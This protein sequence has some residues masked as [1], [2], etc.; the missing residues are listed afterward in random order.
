MDLSGKVYRASAGETMD[1]IAYRIFGHE[2]YA[3]ELLCCNP[4]MDGKILM[5]GGER[6]L[7]PIIN[8]PARDGAAVPETAPWKE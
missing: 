6:I 8:L 1:S 3:A 2:K 5:T 4:E 7:I